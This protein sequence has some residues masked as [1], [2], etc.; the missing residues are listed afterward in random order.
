MIT[1]PLDAYVYGPR[2]DDRPSRPAL[3][4]DLNDERCYIA[5]YIDGETSTEED[6]ERYLTSY[7]ARE[8]ASVLKHY[9]RELE[10]GR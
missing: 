1:L 2:R 8:L 6:I 4:V 5:L 9:A 10:A 3:H 7:E